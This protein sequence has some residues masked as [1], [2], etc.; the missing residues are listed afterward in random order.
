MAVHLVWYNNARREVRLSHQS[1]SGLMTDF[2]IGQ[3][4]AFPTIDKPGILPDTI[5]KFSNYPEAKKEAFQLCEFVENK[6][7]PK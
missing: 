5:W 2:Y 4:I 3:R 7:F 1:L 6:L